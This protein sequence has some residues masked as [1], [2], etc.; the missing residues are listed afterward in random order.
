MCRGEG[1]QLHSYIL[2]A[3]ARAQRAEREQKWKEGVH[4]HK[5]TERAYR[6]PVL[7]GDKGDKLPCRVLV[8][9]SVVGRWPC[10]KP[11]RPHH[12][13]SVTLEKE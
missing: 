6:V 5:R 2:P 10:L 4:A 3:R 11:T 1:R 7:Q 13:V 8:R 12:V 9:L